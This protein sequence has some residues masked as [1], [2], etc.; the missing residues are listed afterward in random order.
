MKKPDQNPNQ[1]SPQGET[2]AGLHALGS[3]H[4]PLI[5]RIRPEQIESGDHFENTA[6]PHAPVVAADPFKAE[7]SAPPTAPASEPRH[8][9]ES[10]HLAY[11]RPH[12]ISPD[13]TESNSDF[14]NADESE[15][16]VALPEQD[17]AVSTSGLLRPDFSPQLGPAPSDADNE[18]A[19]RDDAVD[20]ASYDAEAS[21]EIQPQDDF[22]TEAAPFSPE[23][24]VDAWSGPAPIQPPS[25]AKQPAAGG[26]IRRVQLDEAQIIETAA[27]L[28][29][30]HLSEPEFRA[31]GRLLESEAARFGIDESQIRRIRAG[32]ERQTQPRTVEAQVR[33]ATAS[34]LPD[35]ADEEAELIY[36]ATSGNTSDGD[37]FNDFQLELA[38]TTSDT[39]ADTEMAK[40]APELPQASERASA[41]SVFK[42]L[43][44]KLKPEPEAS[45]DFQ[46]EAPIQ[47]DFL[48]PAPSDETDDSAV[49]DELLVD[50]SERA[51]SNATEV[52]EAEIFEAEERERRADFRA[53]REDMPALYEPGL[54]PIDEDAGEATVVTNTVLSGFKSLF[55][56][57]GSKKSKPA[58]TAPD[59]P[60]PDWVPEGYAPSPVPSTTLEPQEPHLEMPPAAEPPAGQPPTV[61]DGS[62][63]QAAG[64]PPHNPSSTASWPPVTTGEGKLPEPVYP[65]SPTDGEMATE[66]VDLAYGPTNQPYAPDLAG[67]PA[68]TEVP[69]AEPK[70]SLRHR[71]R[72]FFLEEIIENEEDDAAL[73]DE[74][75]EA[76]EAAD[77]EAERERR[78]AEALETFYALLDQDEVEAAKYISKLFP[79]EVGDEDSADAEIPVHENSDSSQQ[80]SGNATEISKFSDEEQATISL[81]AEAEAKLAEENARLLALEDD[82]DFP[83]PYL[84]AEA[85]GYRDEYDDLRLMEEIVSLSSDSTDDAVEIDG[86]EA[87]QR[88]IEVGEERRQRFPQSYPRRSDAL[89]SPDLNAASSAIAAGEDQH[90][91]EPRLLNRNDLRELN[92]GE[93]KQKSKQKLSPKEL[94]LSGLRRVDA[95]LFEAPK[96]KASLGMNEQTLERL[97][98]KEK[99]RNESASL[100]LLYTLFLAISLLFV[101]L[102]G[103]ADAVLCNNDFKQFLLYKLLG[104][105]FLFSLPAFLV[106]YRLS[107]P[108][109]RVTG[110]R[111]LSST[112]LLMCFV[113]GVPLAIGLSS[114]AKI[115][116]WMISRNGLSLPNPYFFLPETHGFSQDLILVLVMSALATFCEELFMR[117]ILLTGMMRSGRIYSSLLLSSLIYSLILRDRYLIFAFAAAYIFAWLRYSLGSIYASM[118]C[119]FSYSLTLVFLYSKMAFFR[120]EIPQS[121]H[122]AQ[123][124]LLAAAVSALIAL[125]VLAVLL[126]YLQGERLLSQ[127]VEFPRFSRRLSWNPVNRKFLISFILL[128]TLLLLSWKFIF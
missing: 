104:L 93:R 47:G 27:R 85:E 97:R 95:L 94:L 124:G 115:V 3:D 45:E 29:Y 64:Q 87:K 58:E 65:V 68:Q 107:V 49:A 117:G 4:T 118:A 77:L 32:Q 83:D 128:V 48:M 79:A 74:Y 119:H 125:L 42:R 80:A 112:S 96:I 28:D 10:E 71:I 1:V 62:S 54:E 50:A 11:R 110:L 19:Q 81:S 76:E 30:T 99:I 16:G 121:E 75:E 109:K 7:I 9:S 37:Y 78:E 98:L 82:E 114:S 26:G 92:R 24:A 70:P 89:S 86:S 33:P 113:T 60:A 59:F 88:R 61:F 116:S 35:V 66:S 8:K 46:A 69:E 127:R 51:A 103:H 43:T 39:S 91:D 13:L 126:V 106:L 25:P 18:L 100:L 57:F 122:G 12:R 44:S 40:S 14:L 41:P 36:R 56:K 21:S 23:D 102:T 63:S 55:K 123:A 101:K 2:G 90:L 120:A 17:D 84:I 34:V 38:D 73:A 105:F 20:P 6:K 72:D 31:M 53:P 67:A 108:L 15:T 5:R 111:S 52:H 22:F